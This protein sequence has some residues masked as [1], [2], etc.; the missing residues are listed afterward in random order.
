MK[1]EEPKQRMHSI[2]LKET[3]E[4]GEFIYIE[5]DSIMP[6]YPYGEGK[7]VIMATLDDTAYFIPVENINWII[8]NY[9]VKSDVELAQ[10]TM[11]K[12]TKVKNHDV[13]VV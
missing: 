1:E 4:D 7:P 11:A 13:S 6:T 9:G 12:R 3:N 10:T 2:V 5:A 8:Q